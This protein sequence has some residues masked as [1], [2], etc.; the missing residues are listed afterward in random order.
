MLVNMQHDD[1]TPFRTQTHTF[2]VKRAKTNHA[3]TLNR[4]RVLFFFPSLFHFTTSM[5]TNIH[6]RCKKIEKSKIRPRKP[7]SI[8]KTIVNKLARHHTHKHTHHTKKNHSTPQKTHSFFG[9]G[10]NFV[11]TIG[12]K[13][14]KIFKT[15]RTTTHL[16]MCSNIVDQYTI[17][18]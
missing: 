1:T 8:L 10:K 9:N 15:P 18:A 14:V 3:C 11:Q 17:I 5:E 2:C 6:A 7:K 13:I 16:H 12:G 4:S